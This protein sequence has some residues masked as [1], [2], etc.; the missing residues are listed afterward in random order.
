MFVRIEHDMARDRAAY[1]HAQTHNYPNQHTNTR[2]YARHYTR[3]THTPR[4]TRTR[5][6]PPLLRPP[7]VCRER[8]TRSDSALLQPVSPFNYIL[9]TAVKHSVRPASRPL[10]QS[11]AGRGLARSLTHT[12]THTRRTA[13]GENEKGGSREV[14]KSF[15]PSV[16]WNRK[17]FPA[18][19]TQRFPYSPAA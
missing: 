15:H 16:T 17:L 18:V 7:S 14:C 6:P 2:S 1:T 13:E 11:P 19:I 12:H 5:S 9:I 10:L 4:Y 3:V 8:E